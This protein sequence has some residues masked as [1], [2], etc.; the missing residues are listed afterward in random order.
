MKADLQI[1]T[2]PANTD[3]ERTLLG[4]CLLDNAAWPEIAIRL[5]PADF[6]LDSHRRIGS[7]TKS[8]Q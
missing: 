6:S 7:L 1:D 3:A 5:R 8:N 4:A 2:L